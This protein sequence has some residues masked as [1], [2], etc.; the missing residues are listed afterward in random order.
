MLTD[1]LPKDCCK[2]AAI[3][4]DSHFTK[5]SLIQVFMESDTTGV[6]Y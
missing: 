1:R 5:V 3:M 6:E 4:S 2:I